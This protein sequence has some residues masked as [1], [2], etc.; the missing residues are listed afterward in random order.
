MSSAGSA[1]N[2]RLL[3]STRKGLFSVVKKG[4]SGA[5]QIDRVSFLGDSI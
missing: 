4:P 5:W 1:G 3:V 2:D